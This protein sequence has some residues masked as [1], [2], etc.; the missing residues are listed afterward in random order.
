MSEWEIKAWEREKGMSKRDRGWEVD[1]D[2]KRD[3]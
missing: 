1:W 3:R 2:R